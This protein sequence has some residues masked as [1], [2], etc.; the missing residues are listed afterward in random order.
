M[1][2]FS[3]RKI[4]EQVEIGKWYVGWKSRDFEISYRT[5]GYYY[6]NAEIHISIFGWHSMFRLP[7]NIRGITLKEVR[8]MVCPCMTRLYTDTG[9]GK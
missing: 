4:D 2:W 6:D 8:S 9:G 1:K 3:I 5:E 7:G